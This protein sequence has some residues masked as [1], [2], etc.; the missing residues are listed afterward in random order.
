MYVCILSNYATGAPVYYSYYGVGISNYFWENVAGGCVG[1]EKTL[2]SCPPSPI[3]TLSCYANQ[4]AGVQCSVPCTLLILTQAIHLLS[5]AISKGV[6]LQC[7]IAYVVHSCIYYME[8]V[9]A[10]IELETVFDE[11]LSIM[12]FMLG[13]C[14]CTCTYKLCNV[15]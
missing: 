10:R 15:R 6:K 8:Y 11:K 4:L 13:R 7:M 5:Y 1:T 12:C 3:P 9:M 14:S 2:L